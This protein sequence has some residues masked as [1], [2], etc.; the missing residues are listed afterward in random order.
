[1]RVS[2][3]PAALEEIH[4]NAERE[5]ILYARNAPSKY[6]VMPSGGAPIKVYTESI[7]RVTRGIEGTKT[8]RFP[9]LEILEV[10]DPLVYFDRRS[11]QGAVWLSPLEVY[12]EL[13]NGGKREKDAA[14]EMVNGLLNEKY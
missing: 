3:L 13:A 12:L 4:Q 6:T 1:M 2:D 8:N 11:D 7:E 10:K 14:K 9:N 5:N